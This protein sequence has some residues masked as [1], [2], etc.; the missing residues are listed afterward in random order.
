MEPAD[1]EPSD[2]RLGT[3][4]SE[5]W[6]WI[7][8][9]LT[10]RGVKVPSKKE[11]RRWSQ[12]GL[13]G[14]PWQ[15]HLLDVAGSTTFYPAGTIGR[16]VAI[17]R[18]RSASRRR[19]DTLRFELWWQGEEVDRAPIRSTLTSEVARWCKE[20]AAL[21]EQHRGDPAGFADA[22]ERL[23]HDGYRKPRAAP[24]RLVLWRLGQNV[25]DFFSFINLIAYIAAGGELPRDAL[26]AES[27]E[28]TPEQILAGA[29]GVTR[30]RTDVWP[31]AEPVLNEPLDVLAVF[32]ELADAGVLDPTR[33]PSLVA[34]AVDD[35]LDLARDRGRTLIEGLGA[36]AASVE[37]IRGRDAF[38]FGYLAV[39]FRK[40]ALPRVRRQAVAVLL[41]AARA[42][43]DVCLETLMTTI[44]REASLGVALGEFVRS[45][46]DS[47]SAMR[48]LAREGPDGIDEA[49]ARRIQEE[50]TQF[51]AERPE[52]ARQL[53]LK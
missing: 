18:I 10:A 34:E 41:V 50:M 9:A 5:A 27:A 19:M 14:E 43:P 31:G 23:A 45:H 33:L 12:A 48:R 49:E 20:P 13:L 6:P 4:A 40:W 21:Y 52:L 3:P 44:S 47:T 26:H 42:L 29:I 22:L 46:P 15:E 24:L 39:L 38:G 30:A 1:L 25:E 36:A 35:D 8:E 11:R 16:I 32:E 7:R 2:T 17:Q 51:L 28:R 37:R 53:E